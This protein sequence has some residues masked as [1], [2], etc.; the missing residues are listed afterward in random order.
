[1]PTD[2]T[3]TLLL[4][5]RVIFGGAF[6]VLGIRNIAAIGR[7][8]GVQEKRGLPQPRLVIMVGIA[9]QIIGGAM[10]ATGIFAALGA[11]ALIVFLYVAAYLFHSPWEHPAAE[12][13]PHIYAW[14]MNTALSGAFLMVIAGAL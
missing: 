12:R 11:A 14:I 9:I 2:L 8:A 5:G 13:G 1:M 10:V 3:T 4:L 6:V 7:L